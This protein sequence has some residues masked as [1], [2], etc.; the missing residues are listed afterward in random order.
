MPPDPD[1]FEPLDERTAHVCVDMQ[2]VFFE[3]TEW[4]TPWAARILPAVLE[5]AARH[6]SATVF[7]RFVPP[8]EPARA[9]G[10][11]RRYH[12]R[13]AHL[14]TEAGLLELAPELQ[15]LL[16]PATRFDKTT[17]SAFADGRLH[18]LLRARDVRAVVVTGLE[19]DVCVLATVLGAVDLGYRVVVARDAVCSSSD[20]SHDDLLD[21]YGRRFSQQLDCASA[22]TVLRGWA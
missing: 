11:W 10:R 2:R 16:P 1:P 8:P 21:H 6:A 22:E 5:I 15:A 18:R 20:R 17:Y 7:T 3:A 4:R 14:T 12:A 13:W 9:P 19:T